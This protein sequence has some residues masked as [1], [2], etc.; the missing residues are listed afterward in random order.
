TMVMAWVVGA[1]VHVANRRQPLQVG[2]FATALS[3]LVLVWS[4]SP[5]S[6]FIFT[7]VE[8]TF[9][10]MYDIPFEALS[11][12]VLESDPDSDRMRV[13]YMVAR[14]IPL[15]LGRL[16]GATAFIYAAPYMEGTPHIIRLFV[17]LVGCV[18]IAS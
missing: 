13:E 8:A 17:A 1:R 3:P 5:L 15:N 2:F 6:I 14:E 9:S 11:H 7:L 16:V 4:I 10:P 18:P 12:K